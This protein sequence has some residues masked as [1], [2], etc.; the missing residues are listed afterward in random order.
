MTVGKQTWSHTATSRSGGLRGGLNLAHSCCVTGSFLSDLVCLR[1]TTNK[2]NLKPTEC[3]STPNLNHST[4]QVPRGHHRIGL[5]QPVVILS[6]QSAERRLSLEGSAVLGREAMR[7][8]HPWGYLYNSSF[9]L[10]S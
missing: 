1:I 2:D 10:G 3:F 9:P 4:T 6:H 7:K 8:Y 5:L